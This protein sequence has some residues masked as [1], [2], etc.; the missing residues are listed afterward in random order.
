MGWVKSDD[1]LDDTRKVKRAWRANRATV[2]LWTM[3]KTY[4]ARHETDGLVPLEWIEDKLPDA[5]ER[6]AVMKVALDEELFEELSAGESRRVKVTRVK[7]GKTVD[8]KVTIGPIGEPG[9]IVHDYLE[10]NEA[11]QEAEERRRADAIR[12]TKARGKTSDETPPDI[13]PDSTQRPGGHD[14]DADRIPSGVQKSRPDPT[15]PDPTNIKPPQPPR[16]KRQRDI[17]GFENSMRAWVAAHPSIDSEEWREAMDELSTR[18]GEA[19]FKLTL[20]ALHLHDDGEIWLIGVAA[21]REEWIRA[22]Y[23]SVL[24]ELAG[25]GVGFVGCGCESGIVAA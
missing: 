20:S 5:D 21:G 17:E 12:K 6:E 7:K 3:A 4:S 16:G 13:Q 10:F 9:Y 18:V 15:R 2:G 23:G 19:T 14:T 24:A 11:R 1:R 8:V 25:K 22:R